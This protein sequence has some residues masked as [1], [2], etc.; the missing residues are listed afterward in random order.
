M[1][2]ILIS[3]NLMLGWVATAAPAPDVT[4]AAYWMCKHHAEVRTIRVAA[5]S[6]SCVTLYAK[7]GVEKGVG[8]GQFTESCLNFL[9]NIK[10]NLE[11]SGWTCRDITPARMTVGG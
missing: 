7:R 2:K 5:M 8:S 1:H 6:G 10:T 3:L 9:T 11:K 4:N